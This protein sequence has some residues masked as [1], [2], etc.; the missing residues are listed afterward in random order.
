MDPVWEMLCWQHTGQEE[1]SKGPVDESIKS[2][3]KNTGKLQLLIKKI[4]QIS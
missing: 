2:R 4:S 3:G 1:V